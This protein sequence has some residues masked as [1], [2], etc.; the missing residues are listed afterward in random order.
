VVAAAAPPAATTV[1]TTTATTAAAATATKHAGRLEEI[2]RLWRGGGIHR[3]YERP[4]MTFPPPYCF[5]E[6]THPTG[7]QQLVFTGGDSEFVKWTRGGQKGRGSSLHIDENGDDRWIP[8]VALNGQVLPVH[9]FH[10]NCRHHAAAM[11]LH[12]ARN[13]GKEGCT[14]LFIS[15]FLTFLIISFFLSSPCPGCACGMKGCLHPKLTV[16]VYRTRLHH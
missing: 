12:V 4:D 8:L 5:S 11:A 15:H 7:Q 3:P 14:T 9:N 16:P 1:A 2:G 6:Y 13:E 10:A